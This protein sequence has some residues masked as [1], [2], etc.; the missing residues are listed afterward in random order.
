MSRK[1]LYLQYTNP[2]GYPPLEHSSRIFAQAGW[3]VIFLGVASR[4]ATPLA[5]PAHSNLQ[6]HLWPF[7]GPGVLQKIHFIGFSLWCWIRCLWLRPDVVYGSDPM[8]CPAL[9][10]IG[11]SVPAQT[12]YHEHDSPP[13]LLK[14]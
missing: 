3:Q 7:V 8:I 12:A 9:W 14:T 11:R 10:L 5:F 6:I 1:I 4:G 2:G 13:D